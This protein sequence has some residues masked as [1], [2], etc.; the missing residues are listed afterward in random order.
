MTYI[1]V[2]VANNQ[3]LSSNSNAVGHSLTLSFTD[4]I[5]KYQVA[6]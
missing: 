2:I 3:L 1:T 6:F 4:S 5:C